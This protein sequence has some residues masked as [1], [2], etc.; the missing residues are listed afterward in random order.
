VYEFAYGELGLK[1]DEFMEMA[2]VDYDRMCT[3]YLRKQEKQWLHTRFIATVL[4]NQSRDPKKKPT[5]YAPEE[6]MPLSIDKKHT[7]AETPED[8]EDFAAKIREKYNLQ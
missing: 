1:P 5:P 8:L 7:E 6:I 2:P 4:I 3:G